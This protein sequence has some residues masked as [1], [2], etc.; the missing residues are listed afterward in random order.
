MCSWSKILSLKDILLGLLGDASDFRLALLTFERGGVCSGVRNLL[1]R[2][3]LCGG[4]SWL[5][6]SAEMS[7]A[8]KQASPDSSNLGEPI[9]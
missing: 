8:P 2:R 7:S 6:S 5:L 9:C 1:D 4:D 3:E